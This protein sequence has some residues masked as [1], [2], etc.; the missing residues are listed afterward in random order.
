VRA[1]LGNLTIT[2]EQITIGERVDARPND[3]GWIPLGL[4]VEQR[5][6]FD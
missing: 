5:R 2:A 3:A 6:N 4:V 1:L